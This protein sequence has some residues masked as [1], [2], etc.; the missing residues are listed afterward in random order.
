MVERG[1]PVDEAERQRS[2]VGLEELDRIICDYSQGWEGRLERV[3][4]L[5]DALLRVQPTYGE[6]MRLKLAAT[7]VEARLDSLIGQVADN[8]GRCL[9]I[10]GPTVQPADLQDRLLRR[11]F[12]VYIDCEGLVLAD[13]SVN[14]VRNPEVVIEPLSWETAPQYADR[15]SDA[16]DPTWHRYLLESAHRYLAS[17]VHHVQIFVALIGGE[18][19]G[20]G[21]LRIEPTGIAYLAN[22]MT[23]RQ[24][25]GHGVY[26]SL[27]AHRLQIARSEGCRTAFCAAQ[28]ATSA[29]ILQRRG[30]ASVCRFQYLVPPRTNPS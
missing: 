26:S 6:V 20:Y 4:D 11:G 27:T 3:V 19:A 30:F 12:T 16:S 18:V 7:D 23:V 29:P 10:V 28:T 21:V 9:W 25:R 5:G 1:T 14:I 15:C 2:P 13:L 24:F 8:A 17:P 22:A